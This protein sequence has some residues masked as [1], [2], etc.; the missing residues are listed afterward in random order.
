M[1]KK[2]IFW[3]LAVLL[4]SWCS[5]SHQEPVYLSFD[6]TKNSFAYNMTNF[7]LNTNAFMRNIWFKYKNFCS[8]DG[9]NPSFK[10]YSSVDLSWFTDYIVD[11]S[12]EYIDWHNFDNEIIFD[13]YYQD[14]DKMN[15]NNLQWNLFLKKVDEKYYAKLYQWIA[16]FGTWNY[17]WNFVNLLIENLG[18][19]RIQYDPN[20]LN[21]FDEIKEKT[22]FVLQNFNNGILFQN[23]GQVTYEW[24]IAYKVDISDELKQNDD[25]IDLQWTLIVRDEDTIELKFDNFEIQVWWKIYFVKWNISDKYWVLS[26][27]DSVESNKSIDINYSTKKNSLIVKISSMENFESLWELNF[28]IESFWSTK[29]ENKDNINWYLILSPRLIYGS[30]L[31]NEMKININCS[32]EKNI[33]SWNFVIQE[34]DSYILLDQILGDSFSLES[35]LNS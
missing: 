24:D 18:N 20:M 15:W 22:L 29:Q 33:L 23:L 17:E 34:P 6:D 27:K 25:F 4:V 10:F 7:Y 1:K 12:W 30:D 5:F 3:L 16:D 31:E 13:V 8:F 35:I 2:L 11:K 21:F 26:I 14:M 9:W 28:T 32:Y 19:K